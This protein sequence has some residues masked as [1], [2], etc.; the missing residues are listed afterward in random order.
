MK[1]RFKQFAYL[2]LFLA[3]WSLVAGAFYVTFFLQPPSCTDNRVNQGEEGVDCGGPCK[4]FCMQKDL[5]APSALGVPQ[6][7]MASDD[8]VSVLLE[9][10][11]PNVATSLRQLPY[12]VTVNGAS[13]ASLELKGVASLYAGEVRRIVLVRPRNGLQAPYTASLSLATSSAQW[14]PAEQFQKPDIDVVNAVTS[15]DDEG[16]RVEGA[17]ASTD[18][19]SVTDVTVLALFYDNAGTLAGA[20]QT[21]LPRL[22][23]GA[24]S[25]FTVSYPS[26]PGIDPDAT[27]VSVTA[28]RP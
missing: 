19:L 21:T 11:N 25:R 7:F 8:L 4:T 12:A 28:Y 17:V 16:I 2:V 10:K 18:V 1:R 26:Q 27:Q 23:S 24:T 3:F 15:V 9:I 20:A 5:V 6:V 22:A 14:A 13:G